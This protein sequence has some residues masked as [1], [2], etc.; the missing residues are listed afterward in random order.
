MFSSLKYPSLPGFLFE[1]FP[2]VCQMMKT[3]DPQ[4]AA[5]ASVNQMS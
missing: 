4:M 3:I 5:L 1:T 2:P